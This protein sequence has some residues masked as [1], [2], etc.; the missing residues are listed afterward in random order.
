MG[1]RTHVRRCHRHCR[2]QRRRRRGHMFS[3]VQGPH[4]ERRSK[5]P[6]RNLIDQTGRRAQF[7]HLHLTA[8][9]RF[10]SLAATTTTMTTGFWIAL[11]RYL[12][13]VKSTVGSSQILAILTMTMESRWREYPS[14][15]LSRLEWLRESLLAIFS[16]HCRGL[17]PPSSSLRRLLLCAKMSAGIRECFDS[18]EFPSSSAV[19]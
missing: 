15:A 1:A 16:L 13:T 5:C 3:E 4:H 8:F 6:N 9:L 10:Q 18:I 12:E 11:A 19:P 2:H 17:G 7:P 14:K